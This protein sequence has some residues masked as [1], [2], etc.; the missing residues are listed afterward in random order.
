M[1]E[2]LLR[3]RLAEAALDDHIGDPAADLQRGR[4]AARRRRTTTLGASAVATAGLVAAVFGVGHLMEPDASSDGRGP[5][6]I[7]GQTGAPTTPSPTRVEQTG[8]GQSDDRPTVG[9]NETTPP[10]P[11][12]IDPGDGTGV[13][14]IGQREWRYGLYHL[15]Q[16]LLDPDG[17]HLNY[18]TSSL[19]GGGNAHGQSLGIKLGWSV[20]GDTGEGM[21]Q[22]A[23]ASPGAAGLLGPC[24][25]FGPCR[26]VTVPGHGQV[27]ISGD[28]DSGDGYAVQLTQADGEEVSIVV[29][30]LFGNNSLTPTSADLVGLDQVL[31][32][33]QSPEFN[34]PE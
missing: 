20:K 13:P 6:P 32:L 16:D 24:A 21:V 9:G 8:P 4:I 2:E 30:P 5:A 17:G 15:A 33:A 28:P 29:D 1:N 34:L 14:G 23:I 7:A 22:V 11:T 31:D 27:R 3:E 25:Y 10:S 19:Q 12:L 18:D 26:D